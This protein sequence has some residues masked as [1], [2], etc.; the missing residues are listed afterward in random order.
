MLDKLTEEQREELAELC[1]RI[2]DLFAERDNGF[3]EDNIEEYY[4]SNLYKGI[5][6]AMVEL[7]KWG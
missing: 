1:N 7:G 3:N 5:Q 4:E 2:D 6:S